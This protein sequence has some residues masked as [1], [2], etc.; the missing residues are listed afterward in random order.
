[1]WVEL[2]TGLLYIKKRNWPSLRIKM[3][4]KRTQKNRLLLENT[5]KYRNIVII[6]TVSQLVH[7]TFFYNK[8]ALSLS[9]AETNKL[10]YSPK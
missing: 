4:K 10:L 8:S 2:N 7:C 6:D 9:S 1:M 5:D 3:K